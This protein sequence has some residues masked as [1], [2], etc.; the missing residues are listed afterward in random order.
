MRLDNVKVVTVT[1]GD[2]LARFGFEEHK[3]VRQCA[4]EAA[5]SFELLRSSDLRDRRSWGLKRWGAALEQDLT[6]V[7]LPEGEELRLYSLES[8]EDG[9]T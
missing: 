4:L 1:Y 3:S 8:T 6:A 7:H 2:H 5:Y 9:G